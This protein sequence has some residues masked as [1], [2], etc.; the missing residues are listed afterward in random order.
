MHKGWYSAKQEDRFGYAI[1]ENDKEEE[2]RITEVRSCDKDRPFSIYDDI[3]YV[4]LVVKFIK[5]YWKEEE[6]LYMSDENIR[7]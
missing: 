6:D 2:V 1:Y 7:F 4:G 3:K 5:Q